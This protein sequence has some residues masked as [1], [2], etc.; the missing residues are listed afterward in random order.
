MRLV[1]RIAKKYQLKVV[2]DAAQA[3]AVHYRGKH[4]GTFGDLGC[5]SFF[6]DKTITT[7]E[8]G[9]I[10]TNRYSLYRK[11]LYLR[12]QGRIN[13][14]S[15]IHSQIGYNFRLTDLQSALGLVQLKKLPQIIKRKLAI[16]KLYRR[17]LEKVPQIRFFQPE[18][19]ADW[20]PFRVAILHPKAHGIMA[21]LAKNNIESRTFFYPLHRQP[22]FRRSQPPHSQRSSYLDKNFPNSIL[23]Y[24]QGV[25]L[26]TY[27]TLTDKQIR[28]V[29]K[30]I[31]AYILNLKS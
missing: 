9:F 15:F 29:C 27:P 14:G 5:F 6:A 23:G 13:R 26:P 28:Y 11:L 8:G 19:G 4:A 16:L 30:T 25:C 31:Q 22:C 21:Y 18:P 10:I 2:E 12:N 7:G 20:L 1:C 24:K 3:I 17:F